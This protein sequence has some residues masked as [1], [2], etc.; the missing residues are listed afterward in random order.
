MVVRRSALPGS[1][2]ASKRSY[3]DTA[4]N[5]LVST[6]AKHILQLLPRGNV[7][8]TDIDTV[9]LRDPIPYLRGAPEIDMW[10][11]IDEEALEATK[12]A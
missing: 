3:N 7:L 8:Y 6:R 1:G 2:A 9:W 10:L 12:G 5:S 11:Q 4:Y